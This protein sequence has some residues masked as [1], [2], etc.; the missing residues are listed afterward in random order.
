[1]PS[2][3]NINC[4]KRCFLLGL[5]RGYI[6]RINGT[7]REVDSIEI[8]FSAVNSW[9]TAPSEVV[10]DSRVGGGAAPIISRCVATACRVVRRT[11]A[12]EDGSLGTQKQ[13]STRL[14][15]VTSQPV[16]ISDS[17]IIACSYDL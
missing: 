15:A 3:S 5:S 14:E 17:T 9:E 2:C 4:G 12:S 7:T 16:K 11:P 8:L 10:A 13:E 1:M 6:T